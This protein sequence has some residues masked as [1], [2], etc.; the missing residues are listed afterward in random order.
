MAWGN[1]AALK[2]DGVNVRNF[3]SDPEMIVAAGGIVVLSMRPVA[4]KL[5]TYAQEDSSP[6]SKLL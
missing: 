5:C 4:R 6:C 1:K 2:R 3:G